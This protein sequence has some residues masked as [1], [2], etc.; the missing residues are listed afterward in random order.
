MVL[1]AQHSQYEILGFGASG[2]DL[3]AA[4]FSRPL[5]AHDR[6]RAASGAMKSSASV[7]AASGAMKSWASV[8]AASGAMKSWASVPAVPG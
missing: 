7:P 6:A 5:A 1:W 2:A 4:K 3:P 8:P